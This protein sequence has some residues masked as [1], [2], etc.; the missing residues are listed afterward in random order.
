MPKGPDNTY[1][2]APPQSGVWTNR[3][4]WTD[5]L[6][7]QYSEWIA[8]LFRPLQNSR[9]RGWRV[10]HDVLRNP[11][12]NT[13]YSRLG[14]SEDDA[15]GPHPIRAVADCGDTP[16]MLRAYFA[17]K[18]GLPFRYRRC[19]RGN[20]RTG[21]TCSGYGDNRTREF[22]DISHPVDR[23]NAFINRSVAWHVHS[24]TLRTVPDD[25]DSDFYPIPLTRDALRPGT[26]FVDTGGHILVVSQLDKE[27][28]FAIDGHP[29]KTVTRRRFSPKYFPYAKAVDT[30]GFKA[31]RPIRLV[32]DRLE[33]ETNRAL[34]ARFSR[35]QYAF[36]APSR[37]FSFMSSL[38]AD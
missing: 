21:P 31:F 37:F 7:R 2:D 3:T 32:G 16:Y 12:R 27:G 19:S 24:G 34:G 15:T 30:G 6:E 8:H 13:L 35:Q 1:G 11:E 9:N 25:N 26:V 36:K 22:D 29:D 4:Q 28:L 14:L 33:A 10:L 20:A 23:F 18:H 5:A 38:I 17:W